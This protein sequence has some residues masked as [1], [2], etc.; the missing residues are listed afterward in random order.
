MCGWGGAGPLC[1]HEAPCARGGRGETPKTRKPSGVPKS[2][3]ADLPA[4]GRA[5]PR[6]G[7]RPRRVC[8]PPRRRAF[9]R[10]RRGKARKPSGVCPTGFGNRR[11]QGGAKTRVRAEIVQHHRLQHQRP[12][13]PCCISACRLA[14]GPAQDSDPRAGAAGACPGP[15][16]RAG[17]RAA[18]DR[19]SRR[20]CPQGQASESL[21]PG[22]G[23]RKVPG[24]PGSTEPDSESSSTVTATTDWQP[25]PERSDEV[26]VMHWQPLPDSESDSNSDAL[27]L[28]AAAHGQRTTA[29]CQCCHYHQ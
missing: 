10:L 28:A 4:A 21:G 15:P 18:T 3:L 17:D 19:P 1:E 24:G 27:W 12:P 26:R 6:S 9:S 14:P 29:A 22:L 13:A 7:L 5:R 25:E 2:L 8:A 20:C 11:A 16:T 23:T